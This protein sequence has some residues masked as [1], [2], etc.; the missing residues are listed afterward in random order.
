MLD[1]LNLLGLRTEYPLRYAMPGEPQRRARPCVVYFPGAST[2]EKCWPLERF[3]ELIARLA[4]AFPQHEHVVL[5]GREAWE[6][7]GRVL[8]PRQGLTNVTPL[9]NAGLEE[10]VALLK[11]AQLLVSNDTGIRNLA[12]ATGTP[13][14]G[15]FYATT[16]FLYW[17]RDGR[18]D[19]V[20]NADG[21]APGV[22]EV[23]DA[24]ARL[25]AARGA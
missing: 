12:I 4:Q 24:A 10:T 1:M 15:I 7:I 8:E 23:F 5:E 25:L 11:G 3:R 20:F 19:A 17:P 22:D 6:S 9:K 13:S 14:V 16:P 18:H 21:E 2:P